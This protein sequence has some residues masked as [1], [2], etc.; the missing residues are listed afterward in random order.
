MNPLRHM[1]RYVLARPLLCGISALLL[2]G[3]AD[4]VTGYRLGSI[5]LYVAPIGT[6][7]YLVGF[8]QGTILSIVGALVWLMA[9]VYSRFG[10][11]NVFIPLWNVSV[12]CSIFLLTAYLLARLRVVRKFKQ[13]LTSFI[14]HDLKTPLIN[15]LAALELLR[16]SATAQQ[17]KLIES[18]LISC[19]RMNHMIGSILDVHLMENNKMV[20]TVEEV[21][22]AQLMME[23]ATEVSVWAA[24]NH[25]RIASQCMSVH[26]TLATDPKLLL[27]VVVNLL[28]NAIKIAPAHS[29]IGLTVSDEDQGV[30]FQVRDAGRGMPPELAKHIFEPFVQMKA[31]ALG[32]AVGTGLGLPF[33]KMAVEFLGGKIQVESTEGQGTTIAFWLPQRAMSS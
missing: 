26:T 3:V 30:L 19:R 25:V 15:I 7:A 27:R 21:D 20:L 29:T 12:R 14:V 5:I 13:D 24:K 23:S 18:S 28:G 11:D 17:Q 16:D 33:C 22:I 8:R 1:H 32:I 2:V 31:K 4:Y 9:D 10:Y 6:V